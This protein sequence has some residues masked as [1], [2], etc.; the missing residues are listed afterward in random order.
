MRTVCLR[1][2]TCI[3]G[4]ILTPC[5]FGA[6]PCPGLAKAMS[7]AADGINET[8]RRFALEW[9]ERFSSSSALQ[10]RGMLKALTEKRL[11][12][13]LETFEALPSGANPL[14]SAEEVYR[15]IGDLTRTDLTQAA[16][17]LDTTVRT[18]FSGAANPEK[19]VLLDLKVADEVGLAS[20]VT[21]GTGFQRKVSVQTSGGLAERTYDVLEPDPLSPLG[22]ICHENKNWLTPLDGPSDGRLLGLVDEFQRDIPIHDGSNFLFFRLNLRQTV[23]GQSD[24][25][26]SR[27]LQ[28]FDNPSVIAALGSSERAAQLKGIFQQLWP[29]AVRYY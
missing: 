9:Y 24:M 19:G 22:G 25:I 2:V 12:G 21:P 4:L 3:L 6:E 26:F 17:G 23:A 18:L 7:N 8:N 27:L 5:V 13:I 28:E 20:R 1:S 16:D 10:Q 14:G 29:A 15:V 11:L